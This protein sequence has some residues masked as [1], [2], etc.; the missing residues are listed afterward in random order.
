LLVL[1]TLGARFA[2]PVRDGD[3]WWQM[4][5]GRYLIEHSTLIADHTVF[6][7][8]PADA[9]VIYCAWISEIFLY[10][11]HQLGGLPALFSFR[12]F[13]LL[14]FVLAVW[15]QARRLG[16]TRHP[17]TW[18]ICLLGVLMSQSAAFIKP[19]IFS[20]VLMTV[21]VL[22]W[23][24][25]KSSGDAGWRYC[26]LLPLLMVIWVN[27]HGGFMFG[28]AFLFVMGVGEALNIL[29]STSEALPLRV[30][31]HLFIGLFLSALAVFVTPYGWHYMGHLIPTTLL[32]KGMA[33]FKTI[34]AY[35]PVFEARARSYHYVDYLFLAGL[36]LVV[37]VFYQLKRRRVDWAVI[38]TNVA[39]AFLYTCFLRTT[40]YWA[41]LFSLTAVHLLGRGPRW[42]WP[43]TRVGIIGMGGA[44]AVLCVLLAG[45]A[46]FDAICKPYGYR[47][48]GFGISYQNPVEEAAFIRANFPV[49]RLG[50]DYSAGGYLLWALWPDTK[51]MIDPRQFPFRDWYGEYRGW[52]TGRNVGNFVAKYACDVWCVR[53]EHEGVTNWFLRSPDWK[54]AFY[55]PSAAVFVRKN[56]PLSPKLP[57]AGRGIGQIRNIGQALLVL[58]FSVSLRDWD[59]ADT[60]LTSMEERFNCPNHRIRVRAASDF[61]EGT[62]AYFGR[63]YEKAVAHLE[64]CFQA[65]TI[66]AIPLLIRC[67]NHLTVQAWSRRDSQRAIRAARAAL[68]LNRGDPYALFN[69]G[70]IEWYLSE[71]PA[72]RGGSVTSGVS[73]L[74]RRPQWRGYLQAFVKQAQVFSH[75]DGPLVGTAQS[76]LSGTYHQRPPL[77]S[78]TQPPLLVREKGRSGQFSGATQVPGR[79][80]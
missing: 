56:M 7:W 70:V 37:L 14:I 18:L 65:R 32:G 2:E 61:L 27:S 4:A 34:R 8:T 74:A 21:T 78:P 77:A 47:W 19:E 75:T 80:H 69:V 42:L 49:D 13:C 79:Q 45:R 63:D 11:L 52:S 12:Y 35:T 23:W 6:T 57:R 15:L 40:Y 1:L 33:G 16:V 17:V 72:A 64:A 10:L 76:I 59:N 41:P 22:T 50:N 48:F 55:G 67:Y 31:R 9:S 25:I 3:L 43:K 62:L 71:N 24:R 60:V 5:Y 51:V 53:Y 36:I 46:S 68:S 73:P 66:Q 54:V 44:I 26:Y 29:F 30:R 58:M 20:Y 38:L 39:F 28:A